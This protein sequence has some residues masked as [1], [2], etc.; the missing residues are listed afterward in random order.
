MNPDTTDTGSD[1]DTSS[2][3]RTS[4]VLTPNTP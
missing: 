3:V 1:V 4:G 2:T